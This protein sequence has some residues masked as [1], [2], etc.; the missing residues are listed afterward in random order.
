M[1]KPESYDTLL[2]H[3]SRDRRISERVKC[4]CGKMI[5]VSQQEKH[6]KTKMHANLKR[7]LEE[8][9]DFVENE[10]QKIAARIQQ[11]IEKIR[12]YEA[13]LDKYRQMGYTINKD[14]SGTYEISREGI[15]A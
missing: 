1:K 10:K 15:N 9:H 2:K 7:K 3:Y 4:D 13:E 12:E 11:N 5:Y 8:Y 14:Q 6:L